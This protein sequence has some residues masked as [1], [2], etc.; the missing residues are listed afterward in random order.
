MSADAPLADQGMGDPLSWNL[1][2]YVR[3]SPIGFLDPS[4]RACRVR[5]DGSQYDDDSGGQSC[6]YVQNHPVGDNVFVNE[7]GQSFAELGT[8]V[9]Y[10]FDN[11]AQRINMIG[12]LS[13][14]TALE[15]IFNFLPVFKGAVLG[16][17]GT[18]LGVAVSA[19][20]LKHIMRR[21]AFASLAKGAG[22]WAQGIAEKEIENLARSVVANPAARQT[23][24]T[25]GR[26][27]Y[28]LDLGVQIGVSING[29]ISTTVRVVVE[30]TG[31]LVT[32]FPI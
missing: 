23:V 29:A 13:M 7:K 1:F 8:G 15:D 32:A 5:G 21:H 14:N 20:A 18:S 19:S 28:E 25:L 27:I 12:E 16:A 3:N 11:R 9:F 24:G 26:T 6:E 4:R 30:S 2:G 22:K 31:Q 17:K 10:T